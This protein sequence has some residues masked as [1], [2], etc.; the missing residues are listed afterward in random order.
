LNV[1]VKQVG[2]SK[3]CFDYV[4]KACPLNS[5]HLKAAWNKGYLI[6]LMK[7]YALALL[8]GRKIHLE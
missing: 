6:N 1:S 8:A 4:K 2:R 5:K 3:A 7:I